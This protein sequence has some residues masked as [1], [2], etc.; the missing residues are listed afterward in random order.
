MDIGI[1]IIK[2]NRFKR[3]PFEKRPSFYKKIFS[4]DEIESCLRFKDPYTHFAAKFA[5]KEA[6]KKSITRKVDLLDIE[7]DYKDNKPIV[8]IKNNYN[9]SFKI[10]ISHD[11]DYAIAVVISKKIK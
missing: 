7:T 6:L 4:K 5:V 11:D 3:I 2:I 8:K 1:D 9:Y 10:S